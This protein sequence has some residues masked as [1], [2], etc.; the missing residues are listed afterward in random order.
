[1]EL[2]PSWLDRLAAAGHVVPWRGQLIVI[3]TDAAAAARQRAFVAREGDRRG[4]RLLGAGEL[5]RL[6]P[7]PPQGVGCGLL[8][9][10]DGQLDP[11]PL[12]RALLRHGREMGVS[13]LPQRVAAV[14]RHG[15]DWRLQL[16]QD[17]SWTTGWLVLC[18]ATGLTELLEPLGHGPQVAPVLGQALELHVAAGGADPQT[19]WRNWPAALVFGGV[20]LVP[21]PG[22]RLWLGATLEPGRQAEAEALR[23]LRSLGGRAPGWCRSATVLRRWQGVRPRPVGR[24]APLLEQLEPGLLLA[25]AHYRNGILLAPA[26]AE[27]VSDTIAGSGSL[28][29]S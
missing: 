19:L 28:S 13:W 18:V 22:G 11:L 2:W 24:P 4:L 16:Q 12:L 5:A 27:W 7:A 23:E 15:G 8:S 3:A 25:T 1:M 14:H 20:N 29:R 10:G 21:R 6:H 17:G 26:T 9:R